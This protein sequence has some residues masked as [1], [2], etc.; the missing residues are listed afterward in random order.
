M[1]EAI[2]P[3]SVT[4][5]RPLAK[6]SGRLEGWKHAPSLLPSFETVARKRARPPQD[7]GGVLVLYRHADRLFNHG[8]Q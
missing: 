6:A 5:R 8:R 7:D 4:L 3:H 2:I 1:G